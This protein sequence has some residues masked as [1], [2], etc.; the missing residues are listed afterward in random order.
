M[1]ERGTG[2]ERLVELHRLAALGRVLAGLAHEVRT[3]AASLLSN[4]EVALRALD[5]LAQQ[6]LSEDASKTVVALRSLAEV[7]RIAAER[8]A[9]IARSVKTLSRAGEAAPVKADLNEIASDALRLVRH[10]YRG[11]IEVETDL[12]ELP[13]VE[14]QPHRIGQVFLNLLLNAGQA[15][16]GQGRV[17]VRSRS[18]HGFVHF[19]FADTGAGIP[20]EN[21][22]CIFSSGFTTKPPGAGTGLGLAI[23]KEIVEKHGG[24]IDFESAPG[25]GTTFHVRLPAPGD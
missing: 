25:A 4:S 16:E 1:A 12:G 11:R 15:I 3:P 5:A 14:C 13:A 19:W 24:S 7:D 18:E 22:E 23:S 21:R 17:T 8:I 2:G 20:A 10:E 9:C 6:P